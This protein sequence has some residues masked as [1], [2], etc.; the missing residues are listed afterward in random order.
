MVAGASAQGSRLGRGADSSA[1]KPLSAKLDFSWDFGHFI[2][3]ITENEKIL[4][5]IKKAKNKISGGIPLE[6]FDRGTLSSVPAS[7]GHGHYR[8]DEVQ[9][10]DGMCTAAE[11]SMG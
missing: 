2:L 8:L 4:M 5:R 11:L 10:L 9:S 3:N 7:D 6:V 1:S